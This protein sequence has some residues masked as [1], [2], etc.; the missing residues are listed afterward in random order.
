MTN[1][2]EGIFIDGFMMIEAHTDCSFPNNI[3]WFYFHWPKSLFVGG[4]FFSQGNFTGVYSL[5]LDGQWMV[6]PKSIF[7]RGSIC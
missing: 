1:R 7:L 6:L 3:L 4:R 5:F 2:V